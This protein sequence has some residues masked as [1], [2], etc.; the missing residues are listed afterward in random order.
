MRGLNFSAFQPASLDILVKV[1]FSLLTSLR[2]WPLHSFKSRRI[3]T[4]EGGG[5][6]KIGW[7]QVR[8]VCFSG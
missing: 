2:G 1:F 5:W 3:E 6:E 7:A 4:K 8:V